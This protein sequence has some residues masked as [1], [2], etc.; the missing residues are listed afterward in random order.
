MSALLVLATLPTQPELGSVA[1][2]RQECQ[3]KGF[4]IGSNDPSVYFTEAELNGFKNMFNREI[5]SLDPSKW[6]QI[7]N[8]ICSG[9]R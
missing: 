8:Q 1:I 5:C 7:V 9:G 3:R 2:F 4:D 6:E